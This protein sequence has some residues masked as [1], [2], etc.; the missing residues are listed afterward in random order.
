[1]RP[2]AKHYLWTLAATVAVGAMVV[3]SVNAAVDP[4]AMLDVPRVDGWNAQKTQAHMMGIRTEK[5]I[6]LGLGRYDAAIF[7]SS[8]AAIGIDPE[9]PAFGGRRVFN[10]ALHA[11]SMEE[12]LEVFRFAAEHQ[13]LEMAVVGLDFLMFGA[14][15][16]PGGEF[17]RS[18]FAEGHPWLLTA[19][20]LLSWDVLEASWATVQA[21]RAGVRGNYQPDGSLAGLPH[22]AE[23][24][25]SRQAFD[26]VLSQFAISTETYGC[27]RYAP[28]RVAMVGEI[29]RIAVRHSIRL[30]LFVS[31]LHAEQ[32]Q[33]LAAMKLAPLHDQWKR[34]LAL[35]VARANEETGGNVVLWDFSGPSPTTT[36][37]VP[38]DGDAMKWYWESSH[39]RRALGSRML[40]RMSED[41]TGARSG[42]DLGTPLVPERVDE[43]LAAQRMAR[44]AWAEA[45]PERRSSIRR[46]VS[47]TE[48]GRRQ[49][50]DALRRQKLL[51]RAGAGTGPIP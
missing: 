2:G 37:P 18:A 30:L 29:V 41:D 46:L 15:R 36:E 3:A 26:R 7:G 27:F 9:D 42:D 47:R 13:R 51:H 33:L 23:G 39:Y 1:M 49:R 24:W 48:R 17:Q 38:E 5:S 11:T 10:A 19:S 22:P 44:A 34:D 35:E 14:A 8:R 20:R 6:R 28:E 31:P 16:Q 12:L 45:H 25:H 50:C 21:N 43:I 40:R 32:L 4:F